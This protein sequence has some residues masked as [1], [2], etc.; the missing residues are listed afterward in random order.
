[1]NQVV[2]HNRPPELPSQCLLELN[3]LRELLAFARA[4][5]RDLVVAKRDLEARLASQAAS[6][7]ARLGLALAAAQ[8]ADE[9]RSVVNSKRA[10]YLRE[11][12]EQL[13]LR[14][15]GTLQDLDQRIG[16]VGPDAHD[17]VA[18]T[19]HEIDQAFAAIQEA[20]R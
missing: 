11:A 10:D 6:F 1:M 8:R 4:Y 19:A 15:A 5:C 18:A 17:A 20:A 7:D 9:W 16:E 2:P 12:L 14:V 13:R 3:R